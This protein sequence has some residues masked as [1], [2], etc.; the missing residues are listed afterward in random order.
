[1]TGELTLKIDKT[2][3]EK[4]TA[5]AAQRGLSLARLVETYLAGLVREERQASIPKGVVD[6]LALLLERVQVSATTDERRGI[7][8][9]ELMHFAGTMD[10]Q[11]VQ[12]IEDAVEAGCE[13]VD[14]SEW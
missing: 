5:Y 8:G 10:A 9:K 4:T 14:L 12:E 6:E 7:P 3:I 11:S 13:Q 2:L 1:M